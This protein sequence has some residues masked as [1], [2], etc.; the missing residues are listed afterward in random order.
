MA[1]EIRRLGDFHTANFLASVPDL[2][3]ILE[4]IIHMA[5][6]IHTAGYLQALQQA[7]FLIR[8]RRAIAI[9]QCK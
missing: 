5:R 6:R 7:K 3:D 8:L 4:Y 2:V 1:Q 9:A